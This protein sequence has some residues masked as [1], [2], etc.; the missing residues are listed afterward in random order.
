MMGSTLLKTVVGL[1][2]I[3]DTGQRE[4]MGLSTEGRT[5]VS[6]SGIAGF[7]TKSTMR[8]LCLS[9]RTHATFLY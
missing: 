4:V 2:G 9:V 5:G 3:D 8:L 1:S 6:P 7:Q